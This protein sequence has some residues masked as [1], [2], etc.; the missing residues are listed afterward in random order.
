MAR[1]R[2]KIEDDVDEDR[3]K[4][5]RASKAGR[6]SKARGNA[7]A[8]AEGE[9]L[10]RSGVP[11]AGADADQAARREEAAARRAARRERR[12]ALMRA[13]SERL[14]EAFVGL[15]RFLWQYAW[16]FAMPLAVALA[17]A[18]ASYSPADPSFSVS[19]A[20]APVNLCGLWG[21]WAA[22]LL[23]SMLGF[24]AWWLVLGLA[25]MAVFA[26]RARW[27]IQRG[28][29][30]PD[31]VNPPKFTAFIGLCAL[32]MGSTSL[33]ALRFGGVDFGLPAGTGGILGN[34]LARA[35]IYYVGAGV[36]AVVFLVLM[37]I[38][39]ALL[40]DFSW[41]DI[42]EGI[43]RFIDEK[44]VARFRKD[45]PRTVGY[46]DAGEEVPA[47]DGSTDSAADISALYEPTALRQEFEIVKPDL[48]SAGSDRKSTRLNSSH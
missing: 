11:S 2:T 23:F 42:A 37:A 33:E 6:A 46:S 34:S 27:R 12:A 44:I 18:L 45:A 19:T 30:A 4:P 1:T 3:I 38:G 28:E 17:A 14:S 39:I 7:N 21:A 13:L 9:V 5:S 8:D 47:S 35:V 15:A 36:S 25:M 40:L 26:L 32:L 43:G 29:T 20:R 31:R 16:V 41:A 24:S 10:S 48:K 22:D